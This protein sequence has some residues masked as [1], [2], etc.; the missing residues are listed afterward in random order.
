MKSPRILPF[1][2][3]Y[4]IMQ[5][6]WSGITAIMPKMSVAT[7]ISKEDTETEYVYHAYKQK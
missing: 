5:K 4:N 7:L 1:R 3:S 6:N 2:F